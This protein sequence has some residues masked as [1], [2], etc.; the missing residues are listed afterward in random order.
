MLRT[1][2]NEATL[3]SEMPVVID[4]VSVFIAPGKG[5]RQ[6][7]LLHDYTREQWLFL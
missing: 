4:K 1:A 3:I 5:K 2:S 6:V 7:S